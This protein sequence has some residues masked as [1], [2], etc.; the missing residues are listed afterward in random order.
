MFQ[1]GAR[2]YCAVGVLAMVMKYYGLDVNVDMLAA[3]AGY[4]E[5]DTKDIKV[6]VYEEAAKEA[7][8]RYRTTG[9]FSIAEVKRSLEKGQP[10]IVW[11]AFSR[12]R[13]A[14]HST[15]AATFRTNPTAKLPDPHKDQ[16]DKKLWPV[17]KFGGHASLITGINEERK[18]VLFTESWGENNRNRRMRTEEMEA[19]AYAMFFFDP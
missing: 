4:R 19:T 16:Q 13:D 2:G 1:Q 15:F 18:E 14:F 12:Q 6:N 10:V 9:K 3:K 5:G 8:V 11:R 17:V 7:K